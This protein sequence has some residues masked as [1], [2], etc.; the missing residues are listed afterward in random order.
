MYTR[1][2]DGVLRAAIEIAIDDGFHI[3]DSFL[4]NPDAVGLPTSFEGKGEGLTWGDFVLPKPHL[5]EQSPGVSIEEHTGTIVAYAAATMA[6]EASA[7]NAEV[8]IDGQICDANFCLMFGE[9]LKSKGKGT[10]AMFAAFPAKAMPTAIEAVDGAVEEAGSIAVAEGAGQDDHAGELEFDWE[11]SFAFEHIDARLILTTDYTN[12]E[13]RIQVAMDEGYHVYHGPDMSDL[14]GEDAIGIPTTLSF[15]ENDIAWGPTVYPKPHAYTDGT[16]TVVQVHENKVEFVVRGVVGPDGDVEAIVAKLNGQICDDSACLLMGLTLEADEVIEIDELPPLAVQTSDDE[17]VLVDGAAGPVEGALGGPGEDEPQTP[18][19]QFLLEALFWGFITLLMPCTYPMIPITISFFTKQA[20]TR[21]GSALP[22]SLAYGAGIVLIYVLIAVAVGPTI[23]IWAVNPWF[24]LFIA[25]MFIVFALSL[26]GWINL[27]P[28]AFLMQAAGKASTTGGYL[29]VFL[30]GLTLVL[31]SF[32]CTAPFVGTLLA[33]GAGEG[34][35]RIIIGMTVFGLTMATPFV[36][37]SLFPSRV[38]KMPSA[39]AWM[40]TLKVFLGFVEIAA[41]LKFLS[42][43]DLSWHWGFLSMEVFLVLWGGIF[44]VAAFFLLGKI[45]LKGEEDG[46]IGPG[47]MVG[48]L[49]TFLFSVY[50]FFLI[51]GFK[52]DPLMAAFAP[53]YSTAPKTV[54]LGGGGPAESFYEEGLHPIIK[55]DHDL[56]LSDAIDKHKLVMINFTGVF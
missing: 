28:P 44:M 15:E 38:S 17:G 30:M 51:G 19:W 48:G 3:Y 53:P 32:T 50:C 54:S 26:F 27:Q 42:N 35:G 14:G 9:S 33:R 8:R 21:E 24:N 37:L 46:A 34:Y 56:A 43:V 36:F 55:D 47:R 7:G 40:N 45:N 29:G 22:L 1:A 4:M 52:L 11:P 5:V 25:V 20:A 10:D 16:G 6:S 23:V 18:L 13:A 31:T 49:V 41:A 2:E 39:G 12:V